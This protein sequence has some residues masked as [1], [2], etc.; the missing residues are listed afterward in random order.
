MTNDLNVINIQLSFLLLFSWYWLLFLDNAFTLQK[1]VEM[2]KNIRYIQYT[3]YLQKKRSMIT[4]IIDSF[5]NWDFFLLKSI[6]WLYVLV[7]PIVNL[8]HCITQKLQYQTIY[9]DPFLIRVV[10]DLVTFSRYIFFAFILF[11]PK[12]SSY[13]TQFSN[14]TKICTMWHIFLRHQ[15]ISDK[16]YFPPQLPQ[17]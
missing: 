12:D 9:L 16:K 14:W 6:N 1:I 2:A 10:N 13:S 15:F 5:V 4:D 3:C 17:R 7:H 11:L 8:S